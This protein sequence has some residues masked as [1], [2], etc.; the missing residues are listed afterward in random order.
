M[1]IKI[2]IMEE[3]LHLIPP[4]N[5]YKSV[6]RK[7]C[8]DY[9]QDLYYIE[10]EYEEWEQNE[11]K[12][13]AKF[14]NNIIKMMQKYILSHEYSDKNLRREYIKSFLWDKL[15]YHISFTQ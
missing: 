11:N 12:R 8:D 3:K 15:Q 5:K 6:L 2:G 13:K 7:I 1:K 10:K 4:K 14:H 9:K